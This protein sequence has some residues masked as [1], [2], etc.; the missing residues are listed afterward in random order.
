MNEIVVYGAGGHAKT[1]MAIIEAA[2]KH[3]IL[4]LLDDRADKH[5]SAFYGYPVL[6]GRDKLVDLK[7][8]G[9]DQAI[10]AIGDNLSR[11]QI[12]RLVIGESFN[13]I[14]AI[15]PTAVLLRGSHVGDGTAILPHAFI[16][17]DAKVGDCAIV[18]VGSVVSHD[19]HVGAF[20]QVCPQAKLGGGAQVGDYAFI[21]M[22]ASVLPNV[23]VGRHAV[24]GA[25]AVVTDDLPDG[26]TAVGVPA[27]IIRQRKTKV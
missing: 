4:G 15:H 9:A 17:A 24:V 26:V 7:Q 6:G 14:Q 1:V 12:A 20:A 3:K 23:T 10:V 11:A 16:G 8:Q 21:G 25:N 13:L 18:S 5:G 19:V 27:R 22:G 2:G